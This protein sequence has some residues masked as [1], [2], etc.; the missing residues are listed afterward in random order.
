MQGASPF[1]KL[2][3]FGA[4][5]GRGLRPTRHRQILMRFAKFGEV[6][7]G[8]TVKDFFAKTNEVDAWNG[9]AQGAIH[10]CQQSSRLHTAGCQQRIGRFLRW[11]CVCIPLLDTWLKTLPWCHQ[12]NAGVCGHRDKQHED[13]AWGV[14]S[15]NVF[16]S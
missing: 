6:K 11:Q 4:A 13:G 2:D 12:L 7:F 5:A 14:N 8:N 16:A 10:L 1:A 3:L 9:E 15:E